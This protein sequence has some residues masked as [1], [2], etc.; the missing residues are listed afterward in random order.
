M[1]MNLAGIAAGSLLILLTACEKRHKPAGTPP[2]PGPVESKEETGPAPLGDSLPP[3]L[4][5]LR[6]SGLEFAGDHVV[7]DDAFSVPPKLKGRPTTSTVKLEYTAGTRPAPLESRRDMSAAAM[8]DPKVTAALG[9]RHAMLKSGWLDPDKEADSAGAEER[10]QSAYINYAKN[11]VVTVL[12]S[13][14]GEV[15]KVVSEAATVQPAESREE[16]DSAIAL[17]RADPRYAKA[18]RGLP[19]RGILTEGG[20]GHRWLFLLFYRKSQP[21]AVF[22]A[23]VDMTAGTV[24]S[25]RPANESKGR[26][27]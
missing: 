12:Q 6:D 27:K 25:A 19:G 5:A 4:K 22:E 10:Y 11:E 26:D 23:T 7:F 13:A 9:G 3:E 17:V 24:V 18:V 15:L 2:N 8:A 16:V 20:N 21:K 14:R 1:R